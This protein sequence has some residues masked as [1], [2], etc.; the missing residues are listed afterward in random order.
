MAA[1]MLSAFA[2]NPTRSD[3]AMTGEIT[4]RGEILPVGGLNEKLLAAQRSDIKTVIIPSDNEKDLT[5]IP[6]Q[7]KQGLKIIPVAEFS[8]AVNYIFKRKFKSAGKSKR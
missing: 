6:D 3:V 1:A 5:E 4:L 7:I 8:D 2:A